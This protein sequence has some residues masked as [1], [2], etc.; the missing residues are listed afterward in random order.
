VFDLSTNKW[1]YLETLPDLKN[2]CM[3]YPTQ[4]I[5]FGWAQC[6]ENVYLTGGYISYCRFDIWHFNL[7][8]LQWRCLNCELPDPTYFH[9]TT[10]T[11]A[12]CLY[13]YH[14]IR[15]N[16]AYTSNFQYSWVQ[17]PTLK[18]M[19]WEAIKCYFKKKM[20]NSSK[21]ELMNLGLPLEFF[22]SIIKAKTLMLNT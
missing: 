9:T 2:P 13:N 19:C 17:V 11:P 3:T 22:D 16:V 6:K 4:R 8:T 12:G 1:E 10:I 20:F 7:K 18:N 21:D 5:E 15:S 14:C